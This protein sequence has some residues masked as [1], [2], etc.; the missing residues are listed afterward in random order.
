M[1]G[2]SQIKKFLKKPANRAGIILLFILFLLLGLFLLRGELNR[3]EQ[4]PITED[5]IKLQRGD[6]IIIV[7]KNGLI[8]YRTQD[9]VFYETWDSSRI[10]S[11]FSLMEVKARQ[12]KT[13][14]DC[15]YKATMYL[16]GKL[17]EFCI[18]STDSDMEEVFNGYDEVVG[19]GSISDYF[20][21]GDESGGGEGDLGNIEYFPTSTPKPSVFPTPT[22]VPGGSQSNYPPVQAGC[23]TWSSLIVRNRAIISNTYCVVQP[24]P[25]P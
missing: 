8:E 6:D 7:N 17:T 21:P 14:G 22:T 18:D 9:N 15:K 13:G 20:S 11:F 12:K 23:D 4:A 16:N 2:T 10:S 5:Q 25:T 3:K 24:T 19:G 1:P